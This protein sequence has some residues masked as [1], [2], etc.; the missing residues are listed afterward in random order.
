ME[1][2]LLTVPVHQAGYNIVVVISIPATLPLAESTTAQKY[3]CLT[4][5]GLACRFPTHTQEYRFPGNELANRLPLLHAGLPSGDLFYSHL[6][7]R[8]ENMA[9]K[10]VNSAIL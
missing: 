6:A 4:R 1:G 2:S 5:H 9:G 10:T 7:I 3:A 8:K